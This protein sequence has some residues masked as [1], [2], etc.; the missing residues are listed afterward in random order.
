MRIKAKLTISVKGELFTLD[1]R[2][3]GKGKERKISFWR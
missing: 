3:Q 2:V 1:S